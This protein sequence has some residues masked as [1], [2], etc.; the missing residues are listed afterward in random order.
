MKQKPYSLKVT[1]E[2]S[3]TSCAVAPGGDPRQEQMLDVSSRL[4]VRNDAFIVLSY[5]FD[6]WLHQDESIRHKD[7]LGDLIKTSCRSGL[8]SCLNHN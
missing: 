6:L 7:A 5:Y 3:N 1:L 4:H 8:S 2:H